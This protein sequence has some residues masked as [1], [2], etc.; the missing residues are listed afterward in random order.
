MFGMELAA[1]DQRVPSRSA[2]PAHGP[3]GDLDTRENPAS[4]VNTGTYGMLP[5]GSMPVFV[6]IFGAIVSTSFMV[7][8]AAALL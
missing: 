5:P 4:P 6:V 8:G 3:N 2:F 7:I 1:R